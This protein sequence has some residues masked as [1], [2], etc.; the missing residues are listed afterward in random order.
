MWNGTINVTSIFCISGQMITAVCRISE[1]KEWKKKLQRDSSYRRYA[2]RRV[3]VLT[4]VPSIRKL[5]LHYLDLITSHWNWKKKL[6][7]YLNSTHL[8]SVRNFDSNSLYILNFVPLTL[9]SLLVQLQMIKIWK[10]WWSM[11][12]CSY[13]LQLGSGLTKH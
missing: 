8:L 9:I 11:F 12:S 5:N 13:T 4:S 3:K 6:H 1:I 7:R 2:S 10:K